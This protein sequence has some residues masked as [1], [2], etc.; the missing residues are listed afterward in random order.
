MARRITNEELYEVVADLRVEVKRLNAR[1]EKAEKR[2]K[3]K[4]SK[5]YEITT[6]Q[7]REQLRQARNNGLIEQVKS[8]EGIFYILESINPA[9]LKNTLRVAI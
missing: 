3:I 8:P 9:Y 7:N 2:T 5:V 4:V 1:L 6:W